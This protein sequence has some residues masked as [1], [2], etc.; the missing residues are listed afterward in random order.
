MKRTISLEQATDL[1]YR[2]LRA[3]GTPE[4]EARVTAEALVAAERDELSSHGLSRLPFY[5]A[6]A[7][8]G[9]VAAAATPRV[10]TAGAL[11]RVDAGHNLAFPAVAAGLEEGMK[12]ARVLGLAAVLIGR[13]HHFGVAGYPVERAAREGLLALAFSNA[14]S[15]MAPWGGNAPL[16]GTNPIAFASPRQ[17]AE[18]V[19]VDLSLSKVARG[20]VMLAKKAGQPIPE[21]WAIDPEGRPTTDPDA[22][23]AGSMVPA[24]DAKGAA[25]AMMVEL[26]TAGLAGAH[27]GFQASSFFEAEGE[28]PNVAHLILLIDPSHAG[29]GYAAH[30][31]Q[32]FRAMLAQPGVRL[33][34]ERRYAA[35][36]AHRE[37]IEL[38]EALIEE[39]Q[40]YAAT[41][42]V[43]AG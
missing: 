15:A 28:A 14:P 8:S 40:A 19:V 12:V 18:P 13:S 4:H 16:F 27:F 23:L 6:Q 5:L 43:T 1:A 3:V 38:P 37:A 42:A 22:A 11:V 36:E 34:G 24:G 17:D 29:V 21:G 9:K 32:L 10:E 7:Q 33:P 35:R 41:E 20:K 31:E 39:L 30:A 26:L 25:L 2:A